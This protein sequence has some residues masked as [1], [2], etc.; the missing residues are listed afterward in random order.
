MIDD[1]VK[2]THNPTQRL[3]SVPMLSTR[4]LPLHALL[5][6][7]FTFAAAGAAQAADPRPFPGPATKSESRTLG[8]WLVDVPH[9]ADSAYDPTLI[10]WLAPAD[11]IVHEATTAAAMCWCDWPTA[12]T[13]RATAR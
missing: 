1:R 4:C 13:S 10:D 2:Y 8:T 6:G 3:T 11:L 12:S 7:I 9:V 5:L